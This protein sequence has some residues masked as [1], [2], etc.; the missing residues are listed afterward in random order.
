MFALGGPDGTVDL[1][2]ALDVL[3]FIFLVLKD[4]GRVF[5]A[6]FGVRHD[7]VMKRHLTCRG[8]L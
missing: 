6:D 3:L 1:F 7:E 5:V 4:R 2:F 8:V